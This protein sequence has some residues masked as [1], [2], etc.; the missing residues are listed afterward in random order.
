MPSEVKTEHPH[1]V[2]V[3]GICGGRPTIGGSRIPV[4]QIALM[5]KAGDTPEDILEAYPHLR[6]AQVYDAIS[7]Y[8]DHQDEIEQEIEENRIESVLKEHS[9]TMDEDGQVHFPEEK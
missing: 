7:Y 4:W 5:F 9:L 1:I 8:L 6:A 2:Q 3:E